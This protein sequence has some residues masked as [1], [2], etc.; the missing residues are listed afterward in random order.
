MSEIWHRSGTP[1]DCIYLYLRALS[2]CLTFVPYNL[3]L[4]ITETTKL[5]TEATPTKL[6][7][8]HHE[9]QD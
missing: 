3:L 7:H 9:Q 4:L 2:N 1:T 8:L 6:T 5:P